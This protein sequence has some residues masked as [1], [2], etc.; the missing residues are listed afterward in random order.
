MCRVLFWR[1]RKGYMQFDGEKA[2]FK[3]ERDSAVWHIVCF[4]TVGMELFSK[5]LSVSGIGA[6]GVQS[7]GI[8]SAFVVS[9]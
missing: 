9:P 4:D 8:F 5:L 3:S 2:G 1:L 6:H 7:G